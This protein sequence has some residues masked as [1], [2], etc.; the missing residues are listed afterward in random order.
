MTENLAISETI[1]VCTNVH[2]IINM[3]SVFNS[4]PSKTEVK[5]RARTSADL[6][7][8]LRLPSL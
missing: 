6:D 4:L 1:C 2:V 7:M 5:A 3:Q 8:S